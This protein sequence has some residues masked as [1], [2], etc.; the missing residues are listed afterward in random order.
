MTDDTK[1]RAYAGAAG[2]ITGVML[3]G[4]SGLTAL[5]GWLLWA[6][7]LL[8]ILGSGPSG[9]GSRRVRRAPQAALRVLGRIAA[10]TTR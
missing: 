8:A 6:A 9:G 7:A 1:M 4:S 10:V 5:A 3:I 2:V